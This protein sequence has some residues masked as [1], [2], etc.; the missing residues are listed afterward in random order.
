ME[1]T[2]INLQFPI[3]EMPSIKEPTTDQLNEWIQNI[4][5]F[6][7]LL[8]NITKGL[9][10]EQLKWKYRPNGWMIKQVVHHCA[11]SHMNS[12]IRFKLALTE[13]TPK[14]R[15]YFEDKWAELFDSL[16]ENI[17]DS[18]ELINVLHRKWVKLLKGLT[19]EDLKKEF[20]HPEHG[21]IFNLAENIG[22]YSWHSLHHLEHIKLAIKAKG[23]N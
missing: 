22:I 16:D 10:P 23:C 2:N 5:Q 14:I 18:I 3:G 9:T 12:Y 21:T 1:L 6:P 8:K 13:E 11:D 4:E 17:D 7:S 19:K 20:A 15:P